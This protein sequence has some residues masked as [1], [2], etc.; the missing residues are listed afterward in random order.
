[1]ILYNGASGSL[2]RYMAPALGGR[3]VQ[4]HALSA[5]LEDRSGLADELRGLEPRTD[6]VFVQMA[7]RVSVP[8][9]EADPEGTYRINVADTVETVRDVVT[10]AHELGREAHVVYVSTGHVYA[11]Q[12]GRFGIA[13]TAPT[14]PR[15]IYATTKLQAEDG[16]SY[17]AEELDFTLTVARV[18]GLVAPI[19]PP[20][21]LLPG[22]IR[23]VREGALDGIPGLS[24]IRDYLDARDVCEDLL[25][26]ADSPGTGP[27]GRRLFNVCSG[28]GVAIREILEMVIEQAG[29][30]QTATVSEAP[31]R[32]DDIAWIV[33]DPS[34]FVELTGRE[35]QTI[36]LSDSVGDAWASG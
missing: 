8:A 23:R 29:G 12:S 5:R 32:P 10:W 30:A 36:A 4:G 26:L 25:L 17:L 33:G 13:E 11:E 24:Y 19:Q 14:A 31:G 34:A 35:P 7:A 27:G 28:A 15:S 2:G 6:P 18:F 22:L 3:D 9:C 20:N 21:Y 1:M 16:L